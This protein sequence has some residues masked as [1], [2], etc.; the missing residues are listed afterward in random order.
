MWMGSGLTAQ[1]SQAWLYVTQGT[2]HSTL[3]S[4]KE[5]AWE[6]RGT[7]VTLVVDNENPPKFGHTASDS[8]KPLL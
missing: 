6:E 3:V 4:H 7:R 8:S 2:A 1:Q 5:N